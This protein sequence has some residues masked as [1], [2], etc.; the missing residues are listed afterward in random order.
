VRAAMRG[1]L[2]HGRSGVW[3]KDRQSTPD[4]DRSYSIKIGRSGSQGDMLEVNIFEFDDDS[5]LVRQITA[6]SGRIDNQGYW[7]FVRGQHD[8]MDHQ[9]CQPDPTREQ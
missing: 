1:S 4:G 7:S 2:S 5:R 3:I 8:A 9:R 6:A